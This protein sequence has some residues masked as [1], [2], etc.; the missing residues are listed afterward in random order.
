MQNVVGMLNGAKSLAKKKA[1]EM[2][3]RRLERQ[4][5]AS[6]CRFCLGP[7]VHRD[8][9][10]H[11]VCNE[12]YYKGK[13]CP[14]CHT[15]FVRRGIEDGFPAGADAPRKKVR[16]SFACS[17]FLLVW[18]GGLFLTFAVNEAL[19]PTTIHGLKCAG[20][21]PACANPNHCI[22]Y[23]GDL[24][25]G[26]PPMSVHGWKPC[27]A[28]SRYK[29]RG[30]TC[31]TDNALY[32]RS[33]RMLGYDFCVGE[34]LY[35]GVL[36]FEDTF[37]EP[38]AS[39]R[40][41]E[42]H[43]GLNLGVCGAME[44]QSTAD[45]WEGQDQSEAEAPGSN[46]ALVMSSS[47]FTTSPQRYVVTAPM[48]VTTGGHVKFRFK[49]GAGMLRECKPVKTA[50]AALQFTTD[51]DGGTRANT[52][53]SNWQNI[54]FFKVV[55]FKGIQ[56]KEVVVEI[57]PQA[58]GATTQFKFV[59]SNFN[60][61][62][63]FWAIDDLRV[64]HRFPGDWRSSAAFRKSRANSLAMI[65]RAQCCI[66]SYE[67]PSLGAPRWQGEAC[68]DYRRYTG[69]LGDNL[70]GKEMWLVM[71]FMVMVIQAAVGAMVYVASRE[72]GCDFLVELGAGVW[73]GTYGRASR[74]IAANVGRLE[75]GPL[76]ELMDTVRDFMGR[77]P[78]GPATI[79]VTTGGHTKVIPIYD[80]SDDDGEEGGGEGGEEHERV[81][82]MKLRKAAEAKE[83]ARLD[84]EE[85]TKLDADF[86]TVHS[87]TWRLLYLGLSAGCGTIVI[88]ASLA[89]STTKKPFKVHLDLSTISPAS[90][91]WEGS[92][93]Y[94]LLAFMAAWMDVKDILYVLAN[95]IF[96]ARGAAPT[97]HIS[98]MRNT[99]TIR[100]FPTEQVIRL[101]DVRDV[102]LV[103]RAWVAFLAFGYVLSTMPY[104]SLVLMIP[105][106]NRLLGLA[107]SYLAMVKALVGAEW[108]FKVGDLVRHILLSSVLV[109]GGELDP[110]RN[111][112][113][114]A[115]VQRRNLVMG[116]LWVVCGLPF[117]LVR[118][119]ALRC[120][121]LLAGALC[122]PAHAPASC[123]RVLHPPA[124]THPHA[125]STAAA[126]LS[127][128]RA[129]CGVAFEVEHGIHDAAGR[130]GALPVGRDVPDGERHPHVPAVLHHDD[131]DG[132]PHT[133][134]PPP[135]PEEL[136]QA[137]AVRQAADARGL[138]HRVHYGHVPLRGLHQGECG[139]V[140]G[141]R[142]G[143]RRAGRGRPALRG[144][145]GE[146][147][148]AALSI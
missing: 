69:Y 9:C 84:A 59:Q 68:W 8:C 41:N 42:V 96:V 26:L 148:A 17:M 146:Q 114:N 25:N 106:A 28:A 73:D 50:I 48:D 55:D 36:V 72:F 136:L 77:G 110:Y 83:K 39:G 138:P 139:G 12:C 95:V 60:E 35:P 128:L 90:P 1:D 105:G 123:T 133:L 102:K 31:V 104:A 65:T 47:T 11:Y 51:N 6:E 141:K 143:Q 144:V 112:W 79:T 88:M 100:K 108:I 66:D 107:V 78:K 117:M 115:L 86:Q 44:D 64:Y 2:K 21:F 120:V 54:R 53:T 113:A 22:E 97:Y 111:V 93:D 30:S 130:G 16:C 32:E 57:P 19:K 147:E 140:P 63:E 131:R 34:D 81:K 38:L 109:C 18:L 10:N 45:R 27:T 145:H 3:S 5:S 101:E 61:R 56:F 80:L 85:R 58:Y 98:G 87:H 99:L 49:Y 94:S 20:W 127:V 92:F 142:C 126:A 118:C 74:W 75:I 134:R 40:W 76:K 125:C 137:P 43:N 132:A 67:C 14:S 7:G 103:S 135:Q 119:V 121:A 89:I 71:G 23:S 33:N 70:K 62:A 37:N 116:G 91:E 82:A 24:N 29:M 13:E 129:D 46:R 124:R 52:T 15:L 4:D 122:P